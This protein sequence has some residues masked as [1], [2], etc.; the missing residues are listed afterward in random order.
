[1]TKDELRAVEISVV[2]SGKELLLRQLFRAGPKNLWPRVGNGYFVSATHPVPAE[3]Q[4]RIETVM[5][6][7]LKRAGARG[8]R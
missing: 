6:A 5:A 4:P 3:L 2:E 7:T 8:G 1:M